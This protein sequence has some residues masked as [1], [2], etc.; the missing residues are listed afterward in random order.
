MVGC[1]HNDALGRVHHA[2]QHIQQPCEIEF[3]AVVAG[4]VLQEVFPGH[5]RAHVAH[6]HVHASRRTAQRGAASCRAST[7]AT[8]RAAVPREC[9]ARCRF[10]LRGSHGRCHGHGLG[11]GTR[12][13]SG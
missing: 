4:A 13:L 10:R 12:R 1:H 11:N 7:A 2:I 8:A 5:R 9:I 6:T 3:V